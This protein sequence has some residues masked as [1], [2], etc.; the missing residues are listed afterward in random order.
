[1]YISFVWKQMELKIFPNFLA[2]NSSHELFTF[3]TYSEWSF[4]ELS[5]GGI[6]ILMHGAVLRKI[7]KTRDG[8]NSNVSCKCPTV[9]PA[10]NLV[11]TKL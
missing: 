3:Y 4:Y 2:Q 1:M 11:E 10:K 7:Y 6:P 8:K 9:V 5:D